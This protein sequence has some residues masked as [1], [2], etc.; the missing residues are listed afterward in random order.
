MRRQLIW[1]AVATLV[2]AMACNDYLG[3][4]PG[5]KTS[6]PTSTSEPVTRPEPP[7][8]RE[9][10]KEPPAPE[11][12]ITSDGGQEP[13]LPDRA[14]PPEPSVPEVPREMKP[15]EVRSCT[16]KMRIDA[17]RFQRS[18]CDNDVPATITS[19]ALAGEFNQWKPVGQ[20]LD[21][22][23][24]RIWEGELT[25]PAG[26]HA[27]KY[28]LNGKVWCTDPSNP[29][30]KY[31]GGIPNS[32]L[33]VAD[34]KQ[35]TLRLEQLK[36]PLASGT[37]NAD[38]RYL[39]GADKKGFDS[40]K[41]TITMNGQPLSKG[42]T[43]NADGTIQIRLQG[44][45]R[46]RYTF[47]V[48]AADQGG[49]STS[50]LYFYA[51]VEDEAFT[52]LDATMYFVFVDRF[53][54]GDKSNDAPVSGVGQIANYQ[55]G[56]L[57]G[58]IEQLKAGYFDKLGVN[59][60]WLSPLYANPDAA[61][62]GSDGRMYTGF[63]GYW[64]TEPRKLQRRYGD[65]QI[66]QEMVREAHKRGIRV[67]VDL[68]TNHVHNTHP[69]WVQN[70][71][72]GWFHP[73]DSCAPNWN[74][75]ITCWFD[76]FLPDFNFSN[77]DA[78]KTMVGDAVY[79]AQE[80]ELDGFR[81]DAVKHMRKI[82]LYNTRRALDQHVTHNLDHFYMVGETFTGGWKGGGDAIKP[83]I[84]P[85]MLSG[86]FDFPLFWEILGTLGRREGGFNF[87]RVDTVIKESIDTKF[88]GSQAIMSTF[89]GNHDVPRFISQAAGV[90]SNM[91]SGDRNKAWSQPPSQPTDE[92]PYRRLRVAWTFLMSLPGVPL[93][94]YGDEIGLAGETDPDNRRMMPWSGLSSQQEQVR[95][96][97]QKLGT[98]R[99]QY[100]ALRSDKRRTL[101][102]DDERYVFLREAT[103]QKI[104]VAIRR[105][106]D[107]TLQIPM[108][109]LAQDGAQVKDLLRNQ[110]LTVSGGQLTVQ[111]GE[112]EGTYLLLP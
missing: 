100:P 61:Q 69:Y 63:H 31:D 41:V 6:E 107:G 39:D 59:A 1:L 97:L 50:T 18:H 8:V 55:G 2:T 38:I 21:D 12:P 52:W 19:V 27:Y 89:L 73:F 56:D 5:E 102:V 46:D 51:W 78:V 22:D 13:P 29:T 67:L 103:N 23:K 92:T 16:T 3:G 40:A 42:I 80:G 76:P 112:D 87:R 101:Y 10:G 105:A 20:L 93:I 32:L 7:S 34:C 90:I 35:P 43:I 110:S 77:W 106:G 71:N 104:V 82:I 85:E 65:W 30:Q 94:Y 26:D 70:Q 24:D 83:F 64:P 14:T 49:Q 44:L 28:V 48:T 11:P 86:Q 99:R 111:L 84:A 4:T 36:A 72:K 17:S 88:Y 91:Y 47:R 53:R 60:L 81:V 58:V 9:P 45:S 37:I 54:N 98:L 95:T 109:G 96:H 62:K 66:L 25:I 33:E 74:K 68:A 79:W 15:V 57:R 108:S 75:P